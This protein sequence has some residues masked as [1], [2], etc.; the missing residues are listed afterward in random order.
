MRIIENHNLKW[1]EHYLKHVD[2]YQK[3]M[4]WK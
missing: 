1:T 3:Y 2:K 4:A